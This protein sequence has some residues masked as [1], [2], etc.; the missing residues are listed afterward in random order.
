M[1]S[2]VLHDRHQKIARNSADNKSVQIKVTFGGLIRVGYAFPDALFQ[3]IVLLHL[4]SIDMQIYAS[5][6]GL[7]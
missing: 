4:D 5:I 2:N 1:M 6:N 7:V 3:S